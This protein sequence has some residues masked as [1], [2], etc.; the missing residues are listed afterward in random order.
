MSLMNFAQIKG[1]KQLQA[2]VA[3]LL[4]SYDAAKVLTKIAKSG[5]NA[6][7][8]NVEELLAALNDK[9]ALISGDSEAGASLK[10]LS[11]DIS[12]LKN[13]KVKDVVRLELSVVEGKATIPSDIDTK[14][15]ACDKTAKLN[16]YTTSNE[17]LLNE[18][19]EQLTVD[20]GT[21]AFNGIPSVIDEAASAKSKDGSL[22]YKAADVKAVKVFPAGEWT[23]ESLP[24]DALLDNSEMQLVAYKDALNKVI[25]ELAKDAG[26]IASIKEQVGEKAIANQL[27]SKA[28]VTDIYAVADDGTKTALYRKVADAVKLSDLDQ[29]LQDVIKTAAI[30]NVFDP[31]EL[32]AEDAKKF[33]K[34]NVVKA[35]AD[36]AAVG[37][38]ASDE[39]VLSEK[40]VLEKL[41]DVVADKTEHILDTIAITAEAGTPVTSFM[42]SQKPTADKVTLYIN[43]IVYFEGEDFTVDRESK[44]A[45]WTLTEANDGFDIDK[46]LASSVVFSYEAL[47]A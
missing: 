31:T 22:V 18:K 12:A 6:G 15:P 16:A 37:Y 34:G 2:N 40:A 23:L 44:T 38:E 39:R 30:P 41:A 4:A 26:L 13:K 7:N 25:V 11:D 35:D 45:T 24:A 20:M 17:V 36:T 8:Y 21:G 9:I 46:E 47:K 33:D 27:A 14:I 42:L 19:G 43:H 5:E 10:S 3:S 32:I 29:D 28:E 1:G